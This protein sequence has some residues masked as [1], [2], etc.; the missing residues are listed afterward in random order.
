MLNKMRHKCKISSAFFQLAKFLRH[1]QCAVIMYFEK[2]N[3][4]DFHQN[5]QE[6]KSIQNIHLQLL[7]KGIWLRFWHIHVQKKY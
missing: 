7:R 1:I 6:R 5:I 4:S 3:V 2:K